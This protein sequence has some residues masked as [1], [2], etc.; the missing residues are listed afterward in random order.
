MDSQSD[1]K[2]L[3]RKPVDLHSD[4]L[5]WQCLTRYRESCQNATFIDVDYPLLMA[6]KCTAVLTTPEL[7]SMLTN[8]TSGGNDGVMFRSDQYIQ[9]GCDLREIPTLSKLLESILNFKDPLV[10]FTAEVSITYMRLPY[11]DRLIEWA[12]ETFHDGTLACSRVII[13]HN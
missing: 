1:L 11:A 10:L 5:P 12:A 7:I 8:P 9:I 3:R 2:P 13:L 4:P 6:K